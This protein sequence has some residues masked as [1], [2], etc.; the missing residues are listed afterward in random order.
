M[1]FL[2]LSV[3]FLWGCGNPVQEKPKVEPIPS[4]KEDKENKMDIEPD[5]KPTYEDP[6]EV[7]AL[8]VISPFAGGKRLQ[9]VYLILDSGEKWIRSYRPI[10]D[11]FQYADKKVVVKGRPY[12][13]SPYVQSVGGTH[14]EL[15]EIRL[16][17]GVEPYNPIP[18]ALPIPPKVDS[19]EELQQRKKLWAH[20]TGTIQS[21]TK[22][23]YTFNAVLSLKDGTEVSFSFNRRYLA[24]AQKNHEEEDWKGTLV[25][26]LGRVQDVAEPNLGMVRLC[27]GDVDSCS[28][29]DPTKKKKKSQLKPLPSLKK[30]PP[31]T[32]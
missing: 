20:C 6:V 31:L 12:T 7:Q 29:D 3:G 8:Y 15:Q 28:I 19:K 30:P 17:E 9:G 18:T 13:N 5:Y 25:T 32:K 11:E 24:V 10:P 26:I 14:F 4:V 21:I 2:W 16:A 23:R 27:A 1:F 22:D